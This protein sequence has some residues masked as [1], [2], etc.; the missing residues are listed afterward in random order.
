M[1]NN[2]DRKKERKKNGHC[3]HHH[4]NYFHHHISFILLWWS[5]ERLYIKGLAQSETHSCCCCSVAKLCSTL[6]DSMGCVCQTSLSFTISWSLFKLTSIESVMPPNHFSLCCPLLL[7]LS[8]FPSIRVFSNESAL[9]IRWPKYWNFSFRISQSF[10]RI[11]RIDF[12][13]DWLV[14]SPC[15][16]RDS[17]ESSPAPQFES[18]SCLALSLL[19]GPTLTSLHDYWKNLSFGYIDLYWQSDVS[20]FEYTV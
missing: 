15:Y 12:P 18:I 13:Y 17:W 10:Q 9:R 14:W 3:H 1:P 2:E 5:S 7:L 16:P 4:H 20:A 6:C 11:F 19:H 8:I